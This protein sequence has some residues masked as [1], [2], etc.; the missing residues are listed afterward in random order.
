MPDETRDYCPACGADMGAKADLP[1]DRWWCDVCRANLCSAC[2]S[3]H[4]HHPS[5]H[6]AIIGSAMP[7]QSG[8]VGAT[9]SLDQSIVSGAQP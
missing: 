4:P 3:T 2:Y 7:G 5:Q 1:G 6:G 8:T 9:G